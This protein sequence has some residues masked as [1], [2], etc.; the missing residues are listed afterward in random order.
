MK[1]DTYLSLI[2]FKNQEYKQ[3]LKLNKIIKTFN[4]HLI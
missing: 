1:F 4:K 3:S 2:F